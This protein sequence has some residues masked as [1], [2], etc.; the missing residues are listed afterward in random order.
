[1][2][3]IM[4]RICGLG[5]SAVLLFSALPVSAAYKAGVYEGSAEGFKSTIKVSVEV[6]DGLIKTIEVV[7]SDDTAAFW[8]RAYP[9]VANRIIEAQSTDVDVVSG[10]TYSSNGIINAVKDALAN[11]EETDP[12]PSVDKIELQIIIIRA[13][14]L[15]EDNYTAESWAVFAEA[16]NNASTVL[17]D[18]TATQETVDAAVSALQSAMDAL[19]SAGT[20]VIP[21]KAELKELIDYVESLDSSVFTYTTW[22][23][24]TNPLNTAKT[25]Y[26]NE[27]ATE[28]EIASALS[29]LQTAVTGLI[30]YVP[31]DKHASTLDELKALAPDMKD[32]ETLYIDNDIDAVSSATINT[33]ADFTID[34]QGH[35]LDGNKEHGFVYVRG[36]ELTIKNTIFKDAVQY[37]R[38]GSPIAGAAVY[39]RRGSAVME[40]CAIIGNESR[41]GAV[42]VGSGQNL[43]VTNCTFVDNIASNAGSGIYVANGATTSLANNIIVG[44]N[45]ADVYVGDTATLTDNGYNR[46]GTYSGAAELDSTTVVDEALNDY[47]SW[48]TAEGILIGAMNHP[49]IN[50]IPADNAYLPA[51]DLNGVARPQGDLGDIGCYEAEEVALT[52]MKFT[53][54]SLIVVSKKNPVQLNI[55]AT[56]SNSTQ[57]NYTWESKN[58]A[59]ATVDE[60][61]VVTPLKTGTTV[62]VATSSNGLVCQTVLRVTN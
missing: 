30:V 6:E 10:A 13:S 3:K 61:G 48:M 21:D 45:T 40:N 37:G 1:M 12:D 42:W 50:V 16:L 47:T 33:Y 26:A 23:A 14:V 58:S 24:L 46:I 2:N 39:A 4:K 32:G 31:G 60:N 22:S 20:P 62:I 19:V 43:S 25:V 38:G 8:N 27:E 44:G 52:S 51:T 54:G 18:D 56:P 55:T 49:A 5:L 53:D 11:A 41:Q 28:E 17:T 34:G 29:S 7:E 15:V 35:T 36:G 59:V 57:Q 9:E